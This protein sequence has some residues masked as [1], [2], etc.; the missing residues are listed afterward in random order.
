MFANV[1]VWGTYVCACILDYSLFVVSPQL[2]MQLTGAVQAVGESILSLLHSS[3]VL[4]VHP[5][6]STVRESAR[7]DIAAVGRRV[8]TCKCT[9]CK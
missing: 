5:G 3:A 9:L 8:H 7:R 4:Q 6:E 2:S 1:R